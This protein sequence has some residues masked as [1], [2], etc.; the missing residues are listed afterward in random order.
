MSTDAFVRIAFNFAEFVLSEEEFET[1]GT[2]VHKQVRILLDL[3][4]PPGGDQSVY[5]E[6]LAAMLVRVIG[7]LG[8]VVASVQDKVRQHWG[9]LLLMENKPSTLSGLC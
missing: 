1:I 4:T 9:N 6:Q 8:P 3:Y 5:P 7:P 2:V